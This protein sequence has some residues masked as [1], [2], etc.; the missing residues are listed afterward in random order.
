VALVI[1]GPAPSTP[2]VERTTTMMTCV[3]RYEID[4][5]QRDAFKKHAE[6]LI[7]V[8]PRCGGNLVGFFLPYEGTNNVSWA[9]V[10]FDK[11]P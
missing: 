3:I 11:E 10:A 7:S 2:R 5:F 6:N 4:L 9:L 8:V 1:G